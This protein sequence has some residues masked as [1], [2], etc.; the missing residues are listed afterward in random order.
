[1]NGISKFS[2]HRVYN[3][4]DRLPTAHTCFNQID[5][6]E[7]ESYTKLRNALLLAIREGHEGFGF[8]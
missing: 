8:A 2:I 6:P 1:M 4:T 3:S 5:L 7:Y